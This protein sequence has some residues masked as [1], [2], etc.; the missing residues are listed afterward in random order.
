MNIGKI[1]AGEIETPFIV[2]AIIAFIEKY[3]QT[4]VLVGRTA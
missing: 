4:P 1:M 2:S 3:D